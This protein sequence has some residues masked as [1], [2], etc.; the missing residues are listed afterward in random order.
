MPLG[1]LFHHAKSQICLLT[2]INIGFAHM[3]CGAADEREGSVRRFICAGERTNKMAVPTQETL[4]RIRKIVEDTRSNVLGNL[5]V[6]LIRRFMGA[7]F[8]HL[9]CRSAGHLLSRSFL[10]QLQIEAHFLLITMVRRFIS[11]PF[12]CIQ[13]IFTGECKDQMTVYL[14]CLR[15]NGANSTPCRLQGKDYLECRMTKCVLVSFP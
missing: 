5:R 2:T 8:L 12:I 15:K 1:A 7:S 11:A 3:L 13:L 10:S 14:N 4:S 6:H 9:Q